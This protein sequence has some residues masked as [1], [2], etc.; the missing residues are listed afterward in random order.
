[1]LH[2][3]AISDDK[4]LEPAAEAVDVVL[5]AD[6]VKGRKRKDLV[7]FKNATLTFLIITNYFNPE[8]LLFI[9]A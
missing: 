3:V 6:A 9:N 8:K 4:V 5:E 2:L 7:L 1:M